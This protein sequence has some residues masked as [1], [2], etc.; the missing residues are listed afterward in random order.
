MVAW[1]YCVNGINAANQGLWR[2]A[3]TVSLIWMKRITIVP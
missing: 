2:H 1:S 3:N